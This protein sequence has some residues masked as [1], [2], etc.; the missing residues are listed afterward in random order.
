MH[1]LFKKKSYLKKK[2]IKFSLKMYRLI[3]I[4]SLRLFK[5]WVNSISILGVTLIYIYVCMYVCVCVCIYVGW[6]VFFWHINHISSSS[7]AART[8]VPDP[9]SPHFPIVHRLR[10]VF[11]TTSRIFTYLLYVCSSWS[12]CFCSA[13]SRGP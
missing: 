8:D 2:S 9:L 7:R 1:C 13:I 12:S 11:W 6:F 10:Q 3:N 5:V 4:S